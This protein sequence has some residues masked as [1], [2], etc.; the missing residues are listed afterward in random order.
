MDPFTAVGLLFGVL[1]LI[2][3][4]TKCVRKVKEAYDSKTGLP[5]EQESLLGYNEEMIDLLDKIQK[6]S[7]KLED[8]KGTSKDHDKNIQVIVTR[9]Q[10][11]SSDIKSLLNRDISEKPHSIKGAFKVA[12]RLKFNGKNLRDL[13]FSLEKGQQT[14]HLAFISFMKIQ[15]RQVMDMIK[16]T[17]V[18]NNIEQQLEEIQSMMVS[19]NNDLRNQFQQVLDLCRHA[20]EIQKINEVFKELSEYHNGTQLNPRYDEVHNNLANTFEW[21]F[22]EPKRLFEVEP[23]LK[24]SFTDWLRN[25]YGIFHILGKPGAG[26]S[27]LMKFIWKHGSTKDML[28]KWAGTSQLLC[29]KYFFWSTSHQ[30][31]LMG[32]RC[33]FLRSALEQAPELMKLLI[34]SRSGLGQKARTRLSYEEISQ[35]VDLLISSPTILERYRIFLLIDGLDEFDEEK[36]AEDHRDLVRLIQNWTF[37]SGGRVKVCVSSREYEAFMTISIHQRIRL[38]RLTRQDMQEYVAERLETHLEFANLQEAFTRVQ[39]NLCDDLSNHR[40]VIKCLVNH[41]VDIAEGIF[42]WTRLAMLEVRKFLSGDYN[43]YRVWKYIDTRPKP[44]LDYLRHMLN[45]ISTSYQKEAY[46]I[47]AMSRVYASM[48]PLE[49]VTVLG[50]S[51]LSEKLD[52]VAEGTSS[53]RPY[54]IDSE[55]QREDWHIF[56]EEQVNA[57]FNGLLEV[58]KVPPLGNME[59]ASVLAF[60]HRSII[61]ILQTDID[62]KLLECGVTKVGL[63]KSACQLVLGEIIF[64][65]KYGH[66]SHSHPSHC[67]PIRRVCCLA[68][69]IGILNITEKSLIG[70]YMDQIEDVCLMLEFGSPSPPLMAFCSAFDVNAF[71]HFRVP[72][73]CSLLVQSSSYGLIALRY[74]I[75]RRMNSLPKQGSVVSD[76]LGFCMLGLDSKVLGSDNIAL[77][78][79]FFQNGFFGSDIR[80]V[81][82]RVQISKRGCHTTVP[83]VRWVES[84]LLGQ[85]RPKDKWTLTEQWLD[86]GANP[87]IQLRQYDLSILYS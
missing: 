70:R 74:W 22:Y 42:L 1:D 28:S 47:F 73:Y 77:M 71:L 57:R 64:F 23:D 60:T 35:A 62:E 16:G 66:S 2:D 76:I 81:E 67:H 25:G 83:W 79:E 50:A 69:F 10:D 87:R 45:S 34:P 85:V 44:L 33:T 55:L 78:V 75:L 72:D 49:Y 68:Y 61:E 53:L 26:K 5:R 11:I 20:Q 13:Q 29:M 58:S 32:L 46:I 12:T 48:A 37:L 17:I 8:L 27:T 84:L 59:H 36:H 24:I 31:G 82:G 3:R 63:V 86:Y 9:C 14:L 52:Q 7:Q 18:N 56:T 4:T 41:I 43:P 15:I 54:S 80:D 30:D 39:E 38:H 51:Y 19:T 40:C 6:D 21:I 65:H